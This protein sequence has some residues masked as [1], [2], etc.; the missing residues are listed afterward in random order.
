MRFNGFQFTYCSVNFTLHGVFL[1]MEKKSAIKGDVTRQ[2]EIMVGAG[3][4]NCEGGA[5]VRWGVGGCHGA[6][7]VSMSRLQMS[8]RIEVEVLRQRIP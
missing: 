1:I 3:A 8:M 5:G 2:E 7:G 4:N 6:E